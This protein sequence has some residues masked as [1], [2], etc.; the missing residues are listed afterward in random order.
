MRK[1][2]KEK[3]GKSQMIPK[4]WQKI[5]D[6]LRRPPKDRSDTHI[7]TKITENEWMQKE[8]VYFD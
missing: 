2:N 5:G 6:L 3:I 7:L 4:T 1:I 8:L